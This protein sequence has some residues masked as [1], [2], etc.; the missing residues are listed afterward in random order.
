MGVPKF[1]RWLSERYP[2]INQ[3]INPEVMRPEFDCLYL[4]MNG[5]VHNCTHDDDPLKKSNLTEN[6]MF[7][8]IFKYIDNLFNLVKPKKVL[9]MAI[10][11]TAPRAKMNQQRQRRFRS[12]Q[13]LDDRKKSAK[14]AGDEVSKNLFDS[15]CITP[16]TEFMQN[17]STALRFFARKK[18]KEDAS[19]RNIEII[20]SGAEVPGEGEHKIML[21]IRQM[22][23]QVGY[24]PNL[25]HCL[26]GLDADLI[27]LSL[28][29]H[30]PHFCML[31]E[32]VIF[33][34]PKPGQRKTL[35]K[36]GVFQFLH[37]SVLRQYLALE[38]DNAAMKLP[39]KWD[40]ERIVD[41][42]IFL[43]F[44]VGNDFLPH[45]PT[46]DIGEGGLNTMYKI[47][48]EL[49]PTFD[50]YV[51][52]RGE[53]NLDRLQAIC[54]RLGVLEEDIF[55]NRIVKEAK[56]AKRNKRF[57]PYVRDKHK[58]NM[59][60][61]K[62]AKAAAA[63]AAY[64]HTTQFDGLR[65]DDEEEPAAVVEEEETAA[66]VVVAQLEDGKEADEE[67][68]EEEQEIK[69]HCMHYYKQ[70]FP[71][72]FKR[73]DGV[74]PEECIHDL[75]K[76]FL[77]GMVWVLKYYFQG[78]AS[79][80]WFFPYRYSPLA[81]DLATVKMKEV[82]FDMGKPFRPFEQLL[83]TLPPQ[84]S[85]LLPLPFRPI[86]NDPNSPVV[87]FYPTSFE[88]DM[89]G[90]KNEWEGVGIIPFI[91]EER[92][93]SQ[94]SKISNDHLNAVEVKRNS[95]RGN[96]YIYKYN[97]DSKDEVPSP[98]PEL[99][100]A[101][102]NAMSTEEV[103]ILPNNPVRPDLDLKYDEGLIPIKVIGQGQDNIPWHVQK[104]PF[105]SVLCEGATLSHASFPNLNAIKV[106]GD[107]REIQLN[108]FGRPSSKE[109]LTLTVHNQL[110]LH[111]VPTSKVAPLL[112][113]NKAYIFPTMVEA[114]VV[115]ARDNDFA[116]KRGKA[117]R[118][119]TD[120]ETRS[121]QRSAR[122]LQHQ[123]LSTTGINTGQVR[124]ILTV[125]RFENMKKMHDGFT[126]KWFSTVEEEIPL[127]L[128]GVRNSFPDPRLTEKPPPSLKENFPV[129]EKVIYIGPKFYGCSGVVT[130]HSADNTTLDLKLSLAFPQPGFARPIAAKAALKFFPAHLVSKSL[131]I[132]G[133]FL[134]KFTSQ[135]YLEPGNVQIGLNLKLSKDRLVVPEFVRGVNAWKSQHETGQGGKNVHQHK[136]QWEYSEK[137]VA[138]LV[139]F[140]KLFP[141][142][143]DYFN[144]NPHVNKPHAKDMMPEGSTFLEQVQFVDSLRYWGKKLGLQRFELI[145]ANSLVV[146]E[147]GAHAI[148]AEAS[149]FVD[150]IQ[151]VKVA[152]FSL[153][154][155]PSYYVYKATPDVPWSP[156]ENSKYALGDQ[157]VSIRSDEKV[158]FDFRGTVTGIY[159]DSIEVIFD[160]KFMTGSN[161][162]W[163][164]P[165]QRG[166]LLS[167]TSLI[168]LS[169]A[170]VI[171]P[172]KL[173]KEPN[174]V[175]TGTTKG[176]K[177]PDYKPSKIVF[178]DEMKKYDALKAKTVVKIGGPKSVPAP[179]P[180]Q[181]PWKKGAAQPVAAKKKEAF[182][183]KIAKGPPTSNE[184]SAGFGG[185]GNSTA[186]ATATA[187]KKQPQKKKQ[188]QKKQQAQPKVVLKKPAAVA[189]AAPKAKAK[190][191]AVVAQT[192]PQARAPA[193]AAAR[194]A[195]QQQQQQAQGYS[196]GPPANSGP[197]AQF[198]QPKV[199]S[200][201]QAM[202]KKTKMQRQQSAEVVEAKKAKPKFSVPPPNI[203]FGN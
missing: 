187:K 124:L 195:P 105:Q 168:N 197:P 155:V 87:D 44:L 14:L 98:L 37:T 35:K 147:R 65:N 24:N 136:M 107:L 30:D 159:P 151:D 102:H 121:F 174:V 29:I 176:G 62:A 172:K 93:L 99:L 178:A 76:E 192:Q 85:G 120:D 173:S 55:K 73:T 177:L 3:V 54:S 28:V 113:G 58:A 10:D 63:K 32:E 53:L 194:V 22:K 33:G 104:V 20:F 78:C 5:I 130:G 16:G 127:Q 117:P 84:S 31:R 196:S 203:N 69:D 8:K 114:L 171:K 137:T 43:G 166:Q 13:T 142:V 41:D 51:T 183:P 135:I 161:L 2:Q 152:T 109:S 47:Y 25:R 101:I 38:F 128:L 129:E 77:I 94:S 60:L 34:R 80:K 163:R 167:R 52:C 170:V 175:V 48:T 200:K 56:D 111:T 134:A 82:V 50:G 191:P 122:L 17:L 36:L 144:K 133:L 140:R 190:A 1:Y 186:A 131:K 132:H 7:V 181:N 184:Q 145:P 75:A 125:K 66:V 199:N 4:D 182:Q 23:S 165:D 26:Y 106:A 179:V 18:I 91:D 110:N 116:Y 169:R 95:R 83:G 89:N 143:F 180:A 68:D 154:G 141:T 100:P 119:L 42:W 92:L 148:A 72:F 45:S 164:C 90:H 160:R 15:N 97:A 189:V 118:R 27:M 46:L 11:G 86:M 79:W 57:G 9:Y 40:L 74:S 61:V 59:K 153:S 19:W 71:D 201:M 138:I 64:L 202:L 123:L 198:V 193:P 70:K 6:Q 49:L 157:V 96:E 185:R 81:S 21:Y 115:E 162:S 139:N 12:A 146:P 108:V 39:F 126:R 156:T 88:I 103:Y 150:A 188:K 158:P 67:D 112:V 149:K